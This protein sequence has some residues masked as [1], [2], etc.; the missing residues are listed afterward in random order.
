MTTLSAPV[1]PYPAP[2]PYTDRATKQAWIARRY[3]PILTS[4]V[5]DVGCDQKTLARHLP[6]TARYTGVDLAPPADIVLN[7]DQPGAV[8]PFPDCSFETVLCCDVLEHLERIHAVF[9]ELCRVAASRVLISL[10]NPLRNLIDA[11]KAGSSTLKFYGLPVDPP[12]DRHR[13]FFGAE[14]AARFLTER[15]A[16]N[17]FAVEHLDNR[18]EY[19]CPRWFYNETNLLASPNITQATTW[20]VLIRQS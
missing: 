18:P 1:D 13:W 15:G 16:R 6:P 3:A 8:L 11:I 12:A 14:E 9:D 20:C 17:G 4:T 5:L 19:P 7:L 2:P 10:P